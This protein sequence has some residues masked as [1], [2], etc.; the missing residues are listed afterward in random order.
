MNTLDFESRSVLMIAATA[1]QLAV[2]EYLIE[3]G[4]ALNS[5]DT[6]GKTA[7]ANALQKNHRQVAETLHRAGAQL[8]WT[9]SQAAAELCDE[10]RASS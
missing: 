10:V 5:R 4:A 6:F 9:D 7:L 1:G 3:M 8:G 2:V